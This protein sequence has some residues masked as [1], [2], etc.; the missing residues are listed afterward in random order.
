MDTQIKSAWLYFLS[1]LLGLLILFVIGSITGSG[2]IGFLAGNILYFITCAW[3]MHKYASGGWYNGL[4]INIPVW[5]F[6]LLLAE[7]GQFHMYFWYLIALMASSYAGVLA[8]LV[9]SKWKR[10]NQKK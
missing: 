4:L 8:G 7:E 1:G 9:F 3:L 2:K 10:T 5:V 6:F